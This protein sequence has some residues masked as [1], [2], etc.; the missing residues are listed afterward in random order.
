[1]T[2]SLLK[3]VG[4]TINDLGLTKL[5][6]RISEEQLLVWCIKGAAANLQKI[7]VTKPK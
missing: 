2:N 7:K 4:R 1:M 3:V 5:G 6:M